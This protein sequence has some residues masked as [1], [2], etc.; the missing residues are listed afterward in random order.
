MANPEHKRL[1][2]VLES[3]SDWCHRGR[4][5][6]GVA[7]GRTMLAKL[8]DNKGEIFFGGGGGGCVVPADDIECRVE[9]RVV[10]MVMA[11][12]AGDALLRADVLRLEFDA[13]AWDVCQRRGIR[14]LNAATATQYEKALALG[15][16]LRT[17]NR[18][19]A[20]ALDE[21][22]KGLRA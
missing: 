4:I 12:D 2:P 6:G 11:T 13:G 18:R 20:E 15:I 14:G 19:L 3:W 22:A 21:I 7:T 10:A 1:R 8:I 5:D 9:G 16:S 17:Y